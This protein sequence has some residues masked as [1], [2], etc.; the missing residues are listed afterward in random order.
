MSLVSPEGASPPE[1][2]RWKEATAADG[3]AYYYHKDTK[4]TV[5]TIPDELRAYREA[6]RARK[7]A[8]ATD[9]DAEIEGRGSP[10][11]IPERLVAPAAPPTPVSATMKISPSGDNVRV[12]IASDGEIEEEDGVATTEVDD[13]AKTKT[14]TVAAEAK[15]EE[16]LTETAGEDESESKSTSAAPPPPEPEPEPTKPKAA[17]APKAASPVRATMKISPSGDNVRLDVGLLEPAPEPASP[18]RATMTISPSGDNVRV[19]VGVDDVGKE[20]EPEKPAAAAKETKVKEKE[21]AVARPTTAAAKPEAKKSAAAAAAEAKPTTR[22]SVAAAASKRASASSSSSNKRENETPG[23]AAAAGVYGARV[24][25]KSS[26]RAS[27]GETPWNDEFA[28]AAATAAARRTR[29]STGG[30]RTATTSATTTTASKPRPPGPPGGKKKPPPAASSAPST[31]APLTRGGVSSDE[32]SSRES[33]FGAT[34]PRADIALAEPDYALVGELHKGF[35]I[36]D[37]KPGKSKEDL[38][39]E[40]GGPRVM[41]SSNPKY[42]GKSADGHYFSGPDMNAAKPA[43][44]LKSVGGSN[45][46]GGDAKK[47]ATGADGKKLSKKKQE[48]LARARLQRQRDLEARKTA[49]REAAIAKDSIVTSEMEFYRE[50]VGKMATRYNSVVND[51]IRIEKELAQLQIDFAAQELKNQTLADDGRSYRGGGGAIQVRSIQKFFT[52]RSVSTFD[53]VPFQ[54]TDALFLYGMALRASS[55]LPRRSGTRTSP[56]RRPRSPSTRSNV[57]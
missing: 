48:E 19:D 23:T 39:R 22:S 13:E 5:W 2:P 15:E 37:A 9:A 33:R 34:K 1:R 41:F 4:E 25:K 43:S 7:A 8:A 38:A 55:S 50:I 52:H 17:A 11:P 29:A 16:S 51:K 12:D 44:M 54:L 24:W 35:L 47:I 45:K 21:V 49:A 26:A 28:S 57:G 46:D 36:S 14:K 27:A 6:K 30:I 31:V 10:T 40:K 32:P 53:R 18:V 42:R 20:G 3:R 56:A